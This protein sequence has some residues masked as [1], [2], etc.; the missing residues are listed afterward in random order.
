MLFKYQ[1][2]I[3]YNKSGKKYNNNVDIKI[4][5]LVLGEK[6]T[7]FLKSLEFNNQLKYI[8]FPNILKKE[9]FKIIKNDDLSN[10]NCSICLEPIKKSNMGITSCNHTFCYSC[11]KRNLQNS[12]H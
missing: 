11:I 2:H 9:R 8:C 6:Q 1:E 5:D 3:F 10:D 12:L 7:K 4:K